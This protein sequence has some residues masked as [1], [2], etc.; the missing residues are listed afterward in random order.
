MCYLQYQDLGPWLTIPSDNDATPLQSPNTSHGY[1][2]QSNYF[3]PL[4]DQPH[5]AT[6]PAAK[7]E[8]S[9][10]NISAAP[11]SG[12]S[13]DTDRTPSAPEEVQ[14][15]TTP[16]L[17]QASPTNASDD[18][19]VDDKRDSDS[20]LAAPTNGARRAS[21]KEQKTNFL[22]GVP[23]TNGNRGGSLD[24]PR[25]NLQ[26]GEISSDAKNASAVDD[27]DATPPPTGPIVSEAP[28][29]SPSTT[30]TKK[31]AWNLSWL[32]KQ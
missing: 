26:L 31:S 2:Q 11:V 14:E 18:A 17:A 29:P 5:A 1:D 32:K 10:V 25:P 24:I 4:P 9:S 21:F 13:S 23:P 7:Q 30:Q 12:T 16:T 20:D 22:L 3:P 28:L 19:P 15:T 27:D 6:R 8:A